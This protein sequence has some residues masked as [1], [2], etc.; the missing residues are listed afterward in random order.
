[1]DLKERLNLY[2]K[3]L[4]S[5]GVNPE[6]TDLDKIEP[7]KRGFQVGFNN[8]RLPLCWKNLEPDTIRYFRRTVDSFAIKETGFEVAKKWSNGVFELVKK[9]YEQEK[10]VFEKYFPTNLFPSVY[11]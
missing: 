10:A 5:K 2:S 8:A 4:L 7:D 6:E 3:E 11:I 9:S 1:M